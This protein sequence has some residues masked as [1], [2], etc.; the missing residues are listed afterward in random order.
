MHPFM[1]RTWQEIPSSDIASKYLEALGKEKAL[2]RKYAPAALVDG[3]EIDEKIHELV[4][5]NIPEALQNLERSLTIAFLSINEVSGPAFHLSL[6]LQRFDLTTTADTPENISLSWAIWSLR[7]LRGEIQ[8][9]VEE[10]EAF[11]VLLKRVISV[12][13]GIEGREYASE[14]FPEMSLASMDTLDM[15]ALISIA[16]GIAHSE[17]ARSHTG[18]YIGWRSGERNCDLN[19]P[20]RE[21]QR[22]ALKF[23]AGGRFRGRGSRDSC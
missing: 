10:L 13:Y 2:H 8:R 3:N 15:T 7:H 14:V 18:G 20:S 6:M 19:F 1:L 21:K 22:D 23:A 4:T 9:R 5:M 11:R 17:T 12:R 16:L